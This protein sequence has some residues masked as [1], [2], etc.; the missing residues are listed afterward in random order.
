MGHDDN[1]DNVEDS[2][3]PWWS[4]FH[5]LGADADRRFAE[6]F[7]SEQDRRS[8][9]AD[10]AVCQIVDVVA[11]HLPAENRA[12][13]AEEAHRRVIAGEPLTG[14]VQRA[15]ADEER[16]LRPEREYSKRALD[17]LEAKAA[18]L[19][20]A[21]DA[22]GA[23][24]AKE[25]ARA[26][27]KNT[28]EVRED[29]EAVDVS[30]S[31][32]SRDGSF[33]DEEEGTE[34]SAATDANQPPERLQG[35]RL[36]SALYEAPLRTEEEG[37]EFLRRVRRRKEMPPISAEH[38]RNAKAML[39]A[40]E[41]IVVG[42]DARAW[43]L[44]RSALDC[45]RSDEARYVAVNSILENFVRAHNGARRSRMMKALQ[46]AALGVLKSILRMRNGTR[47]DEAAPTPTTP[48]WPVRGNVVE[49]VRAKASS[50]LR[51]LIAIDPAYDQLTTDRFLAVMSEVKSAETQQ[52][53][54]RGNRGIPWA[55]ATLTSEC[56][57]LN[58]PDFETARARFGSH[59][60][61]Q[62][63]REQKQA[64]GK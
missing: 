10:K 6:A 5:P 56:R 25:E 50:S 42:G 12:D 18:A 33:S 64:A 27:R 36:L 61:A 40:V 4:A 44:L 58:S 43:H 28:R 2:K 55:A 21:G 31:P 1:T 23:A 15:L 32:F 9:R 35:A 20:Q 60:G 54:G 49:F 24:K 47:D 53:Q 22:E 62:S 45:L 3:T 39:H 13:A 8:A 11:A 30:R 38:L 52:G 41:R 59:A 34:A 48:P 16:D 37:A 46:A 63:R 29:A 26:A 14:A 57:A 51:D 7:P 17:Q 19:K